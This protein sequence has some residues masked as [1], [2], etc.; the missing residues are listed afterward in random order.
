MDIHIPTVTG[1]SLDQ[2]LEEVL[3]R[4]SAAADT[5]R[6]IAWIND[7]SEEHAHVDEE[8]EERVIEISD[9]PVVGRHAPEFTSGCETHLGVGSENSLNLLPA[10]IRKEWNSCQSV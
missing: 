10:S 7:H 3:D 2:S 6:A 8:E 9:A 5:D 1:R 4:A